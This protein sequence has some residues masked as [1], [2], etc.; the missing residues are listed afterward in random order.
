MLRG[1][2]ALGAAA[3]FWS[4]YL[5]AA[6]R[7]RDRSSLLGAW[8]PRTYEAAVRAYRKAGYKEHLPMDES[9]SIFSRTQ[10]VR[11]GTAALMYKHF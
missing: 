10:T 3:G 8:L 1:C 5:Q 9:S 4:F 7:Q 11:P 6:L 2:E